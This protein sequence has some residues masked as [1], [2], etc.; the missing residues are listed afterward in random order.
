MKNKNNNKSKIITIVCIGI[1]VLY[2]VFIKGIYASSNTIIGPYSN[3]EIYKE[4]LNYDSWQIGENAYGEPIFCFEDNAFQFTKNKYKD[5]IDKV[6]DQYD[7]GRFSKLNYK[8]YINI[9]ENMP[10][11]NKE[12]KDRIDSLIELL[13]LYENGQKRWKYTFGQGWNRS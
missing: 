8:K 5:V 11:D 2:F 10:S 4:Y 13:K 1:V 12:E 3:A 7:I 9:L 6:Y